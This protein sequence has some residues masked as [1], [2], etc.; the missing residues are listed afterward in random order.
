[1]TSHDILT[2]NVNLIRKR[3]ELDTNRGKTINKS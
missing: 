3:E 1:M 2:Y